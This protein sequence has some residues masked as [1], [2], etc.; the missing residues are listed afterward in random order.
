MD[1]GDFWGVFG[2]SLVVLG[3]SGIY[4]AMYKVAK[5]DLSWFLR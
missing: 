2:V 4:S 1:W 3:V 5:P